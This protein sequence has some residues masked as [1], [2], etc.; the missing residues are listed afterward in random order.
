MPDCNTRAWP[1][2]DVVTADSMCYVVSQYIPT[3]GLAARLRSNRRLCGT[4][5]GSCPT[6][7]TRAGTC[8]GGATFIATSSREIHT[9]SGRSRLSTDFGLALT[10][11]SRAQYRC[12]YRQHSEITWPRQ[13]RGRNHLVDDPRSD[14]SISGIR[15]LQNDRAGVRPF[16]GNDPITVL[17]EIISLEPK[18]PRRF[19]HPDSPC[20]QR[21][22]HKA[23]CQT[24]QPGVRERGSVCCRP[25]EHPV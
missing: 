21:V 13:A 11:M 18:L 23:L 6:L 5:C 4:A 24:D 3:E 7:P 12:L 10:D 17:D 9:V 19:S 25:E 22:C 14:I 20:L 2:H 16:G 15:A 1:V 8:I